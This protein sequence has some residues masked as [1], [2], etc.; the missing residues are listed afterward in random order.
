MA[1]DEAAKS[2][3]LALVR[4]GLSPEAAAE[5]LNREGLE[6]TPRTIRRW[7]TGGP[8]SPTAGPPPRSPVPARP[9]PAKPAKGPQG[10][11]TEAGA[12]APGEA[13]PPSPADLE[14]EAA[15]VLDAADRAHDR[16]DALHAKL[17]K[18]LDDELALETPNFQTLA[19]IAKL[20]LEVA[21]TLNKTRPP[22]A[23]RPE[24]DPTNLEAGA[25]LV[26]RLEKLVA[27]RGRAA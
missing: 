1:Y 18:R 12:S 20:A 27:D 13:P 22:V 11:K 8:G 5:R 9:P 10:A 25:A 14:A 3:A 15:E 7:A 19:P 6:V 17:T 21:V 24:D 16:L 4:S 23:I 2:K 26:E